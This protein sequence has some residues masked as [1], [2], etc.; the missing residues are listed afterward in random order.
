MQIHI[1]HAYCI[2]KCNFRNLLCN[3]EFMLSRTI[4][5]SRDACIIIIKRSNFAISE[6]YKNLRM[7]RDFFFLYSIAEFGPVYHHRT[8]KFQTHKSHST[9][10]PKELTSALF[11][12]RICSARVNFGSL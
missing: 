12:L 4:R 8:P 1:K 6:T 9:L 11:D 7:F 3:C 5:K 2:N 10:S